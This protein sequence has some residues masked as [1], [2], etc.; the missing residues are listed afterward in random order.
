AEI[1]LGAHA[2]ARARAEAALALATSPSERADLH[3]AAGL[4]ASY[5]GDHGAARVHLAAAVAAHGDLASPRR[6]VRALSYQAIDAYR[7]GELDAAFAGYRR[8]LDVAE[9]GGLV[10]Q[11]ARLCLNVATACH[12]RGAYAEALAAYE[13]GERVAAALAQE[14][15]LAIFEFDLAKLWA[16]VGAWDR[17]EHRA[18]RAER[19]SARVGARFFVAAARSVLG[20]CALARG[21]AADAIGRF[22][23]AREGFAAEGAAGGGAGGGV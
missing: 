21:D 6:L 9:Q 20:D 1:R 18:L 17:A 16:D 12:Q 15:L 22:A 23:A 8:A 2:E 10:E 13:R 3:E 14:D 19:A 4:A 7:A 5:A 11:I